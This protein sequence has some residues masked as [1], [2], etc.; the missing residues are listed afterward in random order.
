MSDWRGSYLAS[1]VFEK[2]SYFQTFDAIAAYYDNG[3][4]A[5]SA[6]PHDALD[7]VLAKNVAGHRHADPNA[8]GLLQVADYMCAVPRVSEGAVISLNQ[9][10][11]FKLTS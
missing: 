6:A 7:F 9:K 11:E 5:A 4:G 8:R 10:F 1:L 3:Q 2:L